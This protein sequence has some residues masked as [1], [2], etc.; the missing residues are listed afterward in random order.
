MRTVKE[1]QS[2][3]NRN[4]DQPVTVQQNIPQEEL[5]TAGGA[6]ATEEQQRKEE[7]INY[8]IAQKTVERVR[9]GFAIERLS[10]AVL[11]NQ[12]RLDAN[13]QLEGAPAAAAQLADIEA[14]V[15][16]AAGLSADRGDELKVATIAFAADKDELEPLPEEGLLAILQNQMGTIVNALIVLTVAALLI[17]F[18]LR[19][20]I[21]ALTARPNGTALPQ[22]IAGADAD[23]DGAAA[24]QEERNLIEDLKAK[25][26]RTPQA[27]LM[28]VV[29]YDEKKAATLLKQW[30]LQGE[31]A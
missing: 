28:Q 7:T 19:P 4:I 21:R 27:R 26:H 20:A 9:D 29:D 16:T 31:H 30:L 11:V 10:V 17:L 6:D 3:R 23:A 18:G 24:I 2:A 1:Q 22:L 5:P 8:E 25:I 13:A 12:E 15:R 14:L